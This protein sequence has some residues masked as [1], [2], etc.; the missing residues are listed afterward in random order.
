MKKSILSMMVV[1]LTTGMVAYSQ[2]EE[3]Q[4]KVPPGS[5]L[6]IAPMEGNLHP[7]IAAE[8][9]KKKIPVVVVTDEKDAEFI[10]AG[11]S[12]KGDDK[13]YHTV[14]GGKDK[15]EGSVQLLSVK[16]KTMIWAGEA[17]DRS[18]WWGNLKRGGQRKV[19]DRIVSKM[20]DQLFKNS[21]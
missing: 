15:N 9:I 6:F 14:F 8:I 5:K 3:A 12:I 10:L 2:K 20:K 19:A 17:G 1:F 4:Q 13:W 16:D 18:L 7:F 11:A 21:H